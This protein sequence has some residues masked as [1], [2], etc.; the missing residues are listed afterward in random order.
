MV[1]TM[2]KKQRQQNPQVATSL[3][4]E[5]CVIETPTMQ[6]DETVLIVGTDIEPSIV[7]KPRVTSFV[8]RPCSSC[9]ALREPDSNYSRVTST[10]GNIRYCKCGFC[11]N[12]WKE[13]G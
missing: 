5:D 10:Q 11:N 6:A 3:K 1:Q 8:P 13:Q 7:P 9:T 12:T 4:P 2:S